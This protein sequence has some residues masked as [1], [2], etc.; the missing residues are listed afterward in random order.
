MPAVARESSGLA[1]SLR[2]A[3]I[4]WTHNDSGGQPVLHALEPNGARR[5]N[6]RLAGARNIDWE[7][8]A[9]FQ[10]DGRAYLLV[11][12]VG[13]N[14][15]RR[16]DCALHIIEEPDP[17][18]LSPL[19]E[20]PATV[21]WSIPV[22]YLDGPRDVES[23]AVDPREGVV[24]LLAKRTKPHGLYTLPLR[25][26]ADGVI[27]AAMPVTQMPDSF[28][29]QP[30]ATQAL[31]PIPTGAYRAQPT[32][33]DF[34]PDGTAAVVLTYGD[35]LLFPRA[36]GEPWRAALARAPVVLAPHGLAQAEGV[37]F[38]ADGR[39]IYV[40]SEGAGAGIMRYKP[41]R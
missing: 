10:L 41:A 15:S 17:A 24:Y 3:R 18:T 21:A 14:A 23:V 25:I 31:L 38:A 35:V 29:P 27:P 30:T 4:L 12:D 16:T 28:L 19:D 7:D 32:G 6:L 36:P 22:R 2:D 5:G 20:T 40:S 26:P 1:P 33:M 11:A 39:T 34:A 13:D 8:L 37:C 9:S